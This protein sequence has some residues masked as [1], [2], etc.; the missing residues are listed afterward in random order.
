MSNLIT[1]RER[2]L[3]TLAHLEPDMSPIDFGSTIVTTITRIAYDNLRK[4]LDLGIDADPTTSHRQMDTVYPKED[5]SQNYQ[6]DFRTVSMKSPWK[7]KA[8]EMPDDSFYDEFNLRWKKASYYYDIVERPLSGISLSELGSAV[9][10]DPYDKGRIE[11]LK[12][13]VTKLREAS[14][15]AIVAD[16]MCGGPFEQACMLRGYDEFAIDLAADPKFARALLDKITETDIA[17]WDAFLSAVGDK[18]DVVCQ[19]DDLGTQ[20]GL[21]ISPKMYREFIK[22]CHKR[23]Y[24]FIHSKTKAKVFMHSCGSVYDVVPDLIE[25]GVQILNPL[26]YT[27]AKMDLKRLKEQFGKDLC[28]WG[29]GIDVQKV[30]PFAS[31]QEIDDEVKRIMDFMM[32]GGG[33]VFVPSH[34]VQADIEPERID[35]AYRAA[36]KYRKYQ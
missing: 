8:R 34:N 35:T 36:L 12:E 18:V 11:G 5:F 21:F 33:Y 28:F 1:S 30:L 7:F 31:L 32:P 9:W 24:D 14:P 6:V 26:Q 10:P 23:M 15:C 22:P 29:G 4:Y 20:N 2:V 13:E 17:L 25:V 19:G 3:T 27:A 16:I